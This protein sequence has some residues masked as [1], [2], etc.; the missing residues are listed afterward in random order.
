MIDLLKDRY[1][2]GLVLATLFFLGILVSVYTIYSLPHTL[3]ITDGYQSS[4]AKVYAI[5]GLTFL[6]GGIAIWQALQY[7]NEVI[8]FRDKQKETEIS[9]K[10]SGD[11]TQTT[12]SLE[13]VRANLS[14]GKNEKET[15]H[16]AL[17]AVCKQLDAGQGAIYMA[18]SLQGI[19]KMELKTGYALSVGEST[20]IAYEDGEGLIGQAAAGAKT[21]YIDEVPEGY[22]KILSGL[23]SASPRFLLIVPIKKNDQVLG[24]MEIASFTAI[25]EDQRKFVEES[26]H[27]IAE[28]ITAN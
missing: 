2:L 4:F 26:A 5:L 21:L 6:L 15:L 17:H 12:I 18:A 8:V 24:I 7:R 27:L 9:E 10:E 28:T 23:G 19:R 1:K 22:I 14:Q 11:T 13:S 25:S 3:M 20:V 16:T